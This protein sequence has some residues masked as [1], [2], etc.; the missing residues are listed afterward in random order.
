[1]GTFSK[2][3]RDFWQDN[4]VLELTPE[5]KYFYLY[6]LTNGR[7]NALGCYELRMKI[8]VLET[9]YNSESIKKYLDKFTSAGKILFDEETQE[10]LI[11]NWHKYNWTKKTGTVNS[12]LKDFKAV[13][14]PIFREILEGYMSAYEIKKFSEE[15]EDLETTGNNEEQ[16][17]TKG[18]TYSVERERERE[19]EK[20]MVEMD[21]GEAKEKAPTDQECFNQFWKLYPNKKAKAAALRRWKAMRISQE[22]FL[23]IMDGLQRALVSQEWSKDGGAYIPHPAT[24]LN[25]GCWEDEYKPMATG[26]SRPNM[27][28]DSV[29]ARRRQMMGLGEENG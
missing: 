4:F 11:V 21:L 26:R 29:I 27:P 23:A 25:G 9:G 15:T 22:I 19:R 17:E 24:W 10:I 14:S 18:E 13:K 5:E 6:L 16:E 12:I 20:D 1:M 2:I 3:E 8:A 7:V 28:K